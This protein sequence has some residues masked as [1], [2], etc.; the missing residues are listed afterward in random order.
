MIFVP[1][2]AFNQVTGVNI[3]IITPIVCLICVFYTSIG[4]IKAVVWTDV[5]Q[6][7]IMI[8]TM[9]FVAVKG[10]LDIGGVN[11]IY[12]RSRNGDR[13]DFPSLSLDPNIRHSMYSVI[14]G[15]GVF[16]LQACTVTQTIV[17]RYLSLPNLKATRQ[18][19][20]IFISVALFIFCLGFYNGLLIYA[21]Y[22]D[23][24]PLTT[25]VRNY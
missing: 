1:A 10:T 22:H 2:L 19:L 25:K 21:T 14:L 13:Y 6:T 16:W 23:C 12:E 17:Q 3:H 11:V 9:I 15:G 7:I 4:G 24:D 18:A 8:G 5:I 20:W